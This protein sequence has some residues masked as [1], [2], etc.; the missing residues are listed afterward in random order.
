MHLQ[1]TISSFLPSS[2]SWSSSCSFSFVLILVFFLLPHF[3]GPIINWKKKWSRLLKAE[4]AKINP[5]VT[6]DYVAF[7]LTYG[8]WKFQHSQKI[9]CFYVIHVT[10]LDSQCPWLQN[11]V[12][13]IFIC[14]VDAELQLR[15]FPNSQIQSHAADRNADHI[16]TFWNTDD[17]I[18]S[19]LSIQCYEFVRLTKQ[20]KKDKLIRK[21]MCAWQTDSDIGNW[22]LQYCV[23]IAS[24]QCIFYKVFKLTVLLV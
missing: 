5:Q 22:E 4:R 14:S 17:H 2:C 18:I 3:F 16:M 20:R 23:T 21:C 1:L 11:A 6:A 7:L 13:S 8:P 10:A 15:K 24:W 12:I 9:C 19:L